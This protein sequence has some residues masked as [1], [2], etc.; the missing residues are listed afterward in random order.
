MIV[1]AILI[2][3]GAG[4]FFHCSSFVLFENSERTIKASFISQAEKIREH[5]QAYSEAIET[6]KKHKSSKNLKSMNLQKQLLKQ[7]KRASKSGLVKI[8]TTKRHFAGYLTLSVKAENGK[9]VEWMGIHTLVGLNDTLR[10]NCDIKPRTLIVID[11]VTKE[12]WRFN[13]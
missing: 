1:K 9:G 2:C 5:E 11:Q 4:V 6:W 7:V 13:L 3:I 8:W 12:E 10:L